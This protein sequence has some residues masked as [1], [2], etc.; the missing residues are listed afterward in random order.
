MMDAATTGNAEALNMFGSVNREFIAVFNSVSQMLASDGAFGIVGMNANMERFKLLARDVMT[1]MD[2]V[3]RQEKLEVSVTGA[4]TSTLEEA[5]GKLASAGLE[6]IAPALEGL[7]EWLRSAMDKGP[8]EAVRETVQ[9]V[10][11]PE[12]MSP[13]QWEALTPGEKVGRASVELASDAIRTAMNFVVAQM[14][15]TIQMGMIQAATKSQ[16]AADE[17]Q[18]TE[19]EGAEL[20]T[21]QYEQLMGDVTIYVQGAGDPA[22]VA[23]EIERRLTEAAD[24]AGST[25]PAERVPK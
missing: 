6:L 3:F 7:T 1:E 8:V 10:V 16:I 22:A 23:A 4:L 11:R 13:E 12:G 9:N 18:R 21:Q 15:E 25:A 14:G 17:R 2:K 19:A 24:V 20:R 5:L